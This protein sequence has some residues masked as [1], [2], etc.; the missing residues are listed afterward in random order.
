MRDFFGTVIEPGD[1][2]LVCVGGWFKQTSHLELF[3]IGSFK[4]GG[5]CL[6]DVDGH[7][8]RY[9]FGPHNVIAMKSVV[10]R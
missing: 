10:K 3:T 6:V 1:A 9:E 5:P 7:R 8:R 4:N 2:V